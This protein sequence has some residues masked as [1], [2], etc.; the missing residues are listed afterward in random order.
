[1]PG[2]GEG[3]HFL[4]LKYSEP[5]VCVK[6]RAQET[7]FSLLRKK[8]HAFQLIIKNKTAENT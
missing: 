6:D 4:L 2:E 3:E 8:T 1:M 7:H 5:A